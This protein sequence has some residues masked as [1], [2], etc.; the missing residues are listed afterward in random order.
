M[1]DNNPR[2]PR[3]RAQVNRPIVHDDD[4]GEIFN[5]NS[6]DISSSSDED[7]IQATR[8]RPGVATQPAALPASGPPSQAGSGSRGSHVAHDINHFFRRGDKRIKDSSTVCLSCE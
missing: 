6:P 5:L 4:E 1:T 2:P 7:L 8:A 3:R